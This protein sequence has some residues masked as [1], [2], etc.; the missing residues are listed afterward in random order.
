MF[1][2][3]KKV[4]FLMNT[5]LLYYKI[6]MNKPKEYIRLEIVRYAK[7]NG[8][9]PAARHY[10][11]SPCTVRKWVRRYDGTIKSLTD[12]SKAPHTKPS[13]IS[14]LL[15]KEIIRIRKERKYIGAHRMKREYELEC[16]AKAISRVL[17]KHNLIKPRRKKHK[18]K[19][20]LRDVKK[21]W[22]AFEQI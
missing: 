1:A 13:K 14:D 8:I 2:T 20:T 10:G 5:P 4:L 15:E 16:S 21:Q 12:Q 6:A 22:K 19:H 7:R 17:H 3:I 18:T 9:K 11:T